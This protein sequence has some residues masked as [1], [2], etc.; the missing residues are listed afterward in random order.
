[1]RF[2]YLI[3]SLCLLTIYLYWQL[4]NAQSAIRGEENPEK[5]ALLIGISSYPESSRW[6]SLHAR[7]D[8]EMLSVALQRQGFEKIRIL[9]DASATKAGITQE[10]RSLNPAVGATVG[11]FFS[12]HGTRLP[13]DDDS[14]F[15]P[16]GFDEALV[17]YD[18]PM[19]L[20]SGYHG[21]NHLRDD[22]LHPL[23]TDLRRK[24]GKNGEVLLVV[25]ACFSGTID[26]GNGGPFLAALAPTR[27][28]GV[29]S[30][31]STRLKH[32][33]M[34]ENA[35]SFSEKALAP[36][37]V[38]TAARADQVSREVRDGEE[39]FVGPL[40]YA[41]CRSL[42]EAKAGMTYEGFFHLVRTWMEKTAST[43]QPQ[44]EGAGQKVM[45]GG[46]IVE[47]APWFLASGWPDDDTCL[48]NQGQIAGLGTGS[49]VGLYQPDTRSVAGA[50][51]LVTG[52]VTESG[53][54]HAKIAW[55][56]PLRDDEKNGW[57]MVLQKNFADLRVKID[58][59]RTTSR[60]WN[61]VRDMV[62]NGSFAV[63]DAENPEL[64]ALEEPNRLVLLTYRRDTLFDSQDFPDLNDTQLQ[65]KFLSV[66]EEYTKAQFLRISARQN[67]D[68]R[69]RIS[70]SLI[71]GRYD[72]EKGEAVADFRDDI[73][74]DHYLVGDTFFLQLAHQ[75][76]EPAWYNILYLE[77]GQ[78]QLLVPWRGISMNNFR[79]QPHDS[80]LIDFP[81]I[82]TS[83]EGKGFNASFLLIA[84]EDPI[85]L[86]GILDQPE[87]SRSYGR[88]DMSPLEWLYYRFSQDVGTR[89]GEVRVDFERVCVSEVVVG[90]MG[91]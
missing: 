24:A 36:L 46:A 45:F 57:V 3:L 75:G 29:E 66:V 41:F 28:G 11:I 69:Y 51:A 23:L 56:R 64:L 55:E 86:R 13:D 63:P 8:V 22:D 59:L 15:E 14:D 61:R 44:L 47:Q 87:P 31:P 84:S 32:S 20:D 78:S 79:L 39:K 37:V 50:E 2:R 60:R 80:L 54:F 76:S 52:T 38:M 58:F 70:A 72:R 12:G 10:I 62:L 9:L 90:V 89:A 34:L 73:P 67:K 49:V 35:R 6:D 4:V 43:Q 91:E 17:P 71:H 77:G 33:G 19:N 26:R 68:P 83:E 40:S 21:E 81:W 74:S 1:M 85:D 18:A 27:S 65:L 88:T 30:G 16:D 25:D 7:R 53:N 82:F 5:I 42:D 48:V